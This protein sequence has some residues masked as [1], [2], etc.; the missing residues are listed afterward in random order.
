VRRRW[1]G[2]RTCTASASPP[3][4]A[5]STRPC[6]PPPSGAPGGLDPCPAASGRVGGGS[7]TI[8]NQQRVQFLP[9]DGLGAY[10]A[11]TPSRS[12]GGAAPGALGHSY[13]VCVGRAGGPGPVAA[14]GGPPAHPGARGRRGWGCHSLPFWHSLS[15]CVHWL[16]QVTLQ[17]SPPQSARAVADEGGAVLLLFRRS[18]PVFCFHPHL[19]VCCLLSVETS[20]MGRDASPVT[21]SIGPGQALLLRRSAQFRYERTVY[22]LTGLYSLSFRQ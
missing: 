16:Y 19:G 21:P 10:G 1:A 5:P 6:P 13:R 3:P 17:S 9:D 15:F 20:E 14:G 18:C 22:E 12:S 4:P 7:G 8:E 2:H 11:L